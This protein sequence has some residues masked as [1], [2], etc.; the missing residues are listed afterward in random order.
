MLW[1]R[2]GIPDDQAATESSIAT[3]EDVVQSR[4]RSEEERGYPTVAS[5]AEYPSPKRG[6][7]CH[8]FD[9]VQASRDA[10]ERKYISNL[11]EEDNEDFFQD[12][13]TAGNLPLCFFVAK[14]FQSVC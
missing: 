7:L 10:K 3:E 6:C 14:R 11:L 5:K 8:W 13:P 9:D 4:S 2:T 12:N 1:S